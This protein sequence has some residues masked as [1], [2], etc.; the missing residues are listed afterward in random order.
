MP[1]AAVV[2]R[3]LSFVPF[4]GRRAVAD[5]LLTRRMLVGPTWR[6]LLPDVYIHADAY[7]A[8]DHRMWCDAVALRLPAGAAIGGLSAAYLHGVDLLPRDSPVSVVLPGTTRSRP[9]PRV[10]VTYADLATDDMTTFAALPLTT[11]VRTAFDLGRRLPRTEALV[12]LDALLH[13]K[14]VRPPELA[15]YLSGHPR[16]P[17]AAQLRELLA[18]AEPRTESPMETRLRL[19][20]LDAGLPPLTAQH[21][22]RTANG[23]HLGRIDLAYPDWR[24]AIEYEGDHHRERAHFRRDVA[25]LNALRAHGWLVLRFTADDVRQHP[26]QIVTHVTAAIRERRRQGLTR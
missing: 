25:R 3:D 8:D 4:S 14:V 1:R 15:A 17:G 2:P 6:R 7:Q 23:R 10:A 13:R 24:I 16:W 22:V 12:A 19:I 11:G 21:T 26:G 20:L 9:H 5:G 18:V